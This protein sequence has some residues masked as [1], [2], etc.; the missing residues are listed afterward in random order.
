MKREGKKLF[1]IYNPLSGR[2]QIRGK[3][4]DIL[5]VFSGAGYEMTVCPTKGPKDATER[6]AELPDD[7]E[8]VVCSG[9]D[10]TLDEVVEGMMRR[11]HR[12]PLGYIP[13]GT[14]N[15]FAKSLK[16]PRNMVSAARLAVEG[17]SF[18][19]DVGTFN[20][21]H[22]VYIAAFGIFTDVAYSTR[23]DLK[24]VLGNVAYLLE[25]VKRLANV[26]SYHVRLVSEEFETE[27]DFIF[28]MVTNSRS[29]GGFK[30]IIGSR[31]RFDDG[32]FEATFVRTPQNPAELQEIL[33]AVLIK[34]IDSKYMYSFRTSR[35]VVEA[36]EDLS[37]TLDGEYG[38]ECRTAVIQNHQKEL[39]IRAG[40]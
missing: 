27:G 39:R 11:E 22:F 34:E 9:G 25:G 2:G 33:A 8:L 21:S 15:D 18:L 7:Y 14:V 28:G 13:S 30:N 29:V 16:I 12:L 5:Q 36:E 26:P 10:G 24:N 40:S 3:L 6:V 38:G 32:L 31:V 19:C 23:Q 37:W 35:L 17:K 4:F 20:D 1:F